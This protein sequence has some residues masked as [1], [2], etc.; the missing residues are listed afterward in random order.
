MYLLK[1]E[2]IS[3]TLSKIALKTRFSP[4]DTLKISLFGKTGGDFYIYGE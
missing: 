2:L 1:K 4:S 3:D